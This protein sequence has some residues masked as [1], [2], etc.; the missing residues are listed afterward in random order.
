METTDPI[1]DPNVAMQETPDKSNVQKRIDELTAEKKQAQA[2]AEENQRQVSQ[3]T[4]TVA[5]LMK[6]QFEPAPKVKEPEPLPEG[7]DPGLAKFFLD[8]MAQMQYD[9]KQQM[10]QLSWQMQNQYDQQQVGQ[11]YSNLPPEVIKD[12]A[13][14]FTNLK[15]QYGADKVSMDDAIAVAY[16]QWHLKQQGQQRAQQFNQMGQPLMM[17]SAAVPQQQSTGLVSPTSL[18]GWDDMDNA[19]Q[20]KLITEW[21]K[22]GGKLL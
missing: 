5:E 2:L 21:E 4:Q 6:R 3:L 13:G 7:V 20:N 1:I 16:F 19:T 15:Q 18:P 17:Q 9:T 12:A 8:K 14:R 10:Q 11:K 22:K